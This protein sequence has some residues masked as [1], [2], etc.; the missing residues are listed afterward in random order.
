VRTIWGIESTTE[1]IER[2]DCFGRN[3]VRERV[4]IEDLSLVKRNAV[5]E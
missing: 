3:N 2:A 5:L 1:A 4:K